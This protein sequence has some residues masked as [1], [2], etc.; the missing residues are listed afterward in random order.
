MR[1]LKTLFLLLCFTP[2]LSVQA[3]FMKKLKEKVAEVSEKVSGPETTQNQNG[4]ATPAGGPATSGN[5]NPRNTSG[6]GLISTQPDVK[7]NLTSAETSFGG[8]KYS[9][10]RYAVQQAMLGVELEIGQ[11]ILKSLPQTIGD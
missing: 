5:N 8:G 2:L 1:N 9:E 6:G 7:E 4:T 3:Q 10:A 11:A